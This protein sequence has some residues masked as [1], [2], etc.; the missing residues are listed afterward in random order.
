MGL[1]EERKVDA[2]PQFENVMCC[3]LAVWLAGWYG[4]QQAAEY[5]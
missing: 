4:G 1:D 2:A 5:R 3:G